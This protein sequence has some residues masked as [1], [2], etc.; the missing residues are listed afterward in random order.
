[1][2]DL[3]G[4]HRSKRRVRVIDQL[5]K[6]Y[7]GTWTYD[8][9]LYVWRGPNGL[10][11]Y[12]ESVSIPDPSGQNAYLDDEWDVAYRERGTMKRVPIQ[13]ERRRYA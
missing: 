3:L 7:G 12:A 6:L 4:S 5:R 11:V 10:E 9:Q 8:Q 13:D 2:I 1:M